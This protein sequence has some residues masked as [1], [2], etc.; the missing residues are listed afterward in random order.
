MIPFVVYLMGKKEQEV[1]F[2][3]DRT[4]KIPVALQVV[5]DDMGWH[6]G[7]DD[8]AGGG[9]SRSGLPRFHVAEDYRIINEIGRGIDMKIFCPFV[10]G[11]WDK[12]NYLR[13]IPDAN[14]DGEHWD[15]AS[16]I[17]MRNT[18]K[19]AEELKNSEFIEIGFHGLLHSYY[20]NGKLITETEFTR[21]YV[22]EEGKCDFSRSELVSAEEFTKHIDMFKKIYKSWGFTQK[23]R[24]FVSPCSVHTAPDESGDFVKVLKDNGFIYWSNYWQK[25]ADSTAVIDGVTF[26][27]KSWLGAGWEVYD[28]DPMYLI[29]QGSEEGLASNAPEG[30]INPAMGFHWTNFLRYNPENNMERLPQWIMYFKRQGKIFGQ[31]L[32]RDIAFAASQAVYSRFGKVSV[33]GNKYTV[34][35]SDVDN[36][37]ALGLSDEFY[38]S[39]RKPFDISSCTGGIMTI[40]ERHSYHTTYKIKRSG[41]DKV[42]VMLK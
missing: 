16:E 41:D 28:F 10:I 42:T 12:D 9:P 37:G 13:E 17:D 27:Q 7:R 25:A 34:D 5:V 14:P 6:N 36:K 32:A 23:I 8:R 2:M 39:S 18:E 21:P 35:L 1:L 22:D 31:M 29:D 3:K 20:E 4:V 24:G 15:R 30:V 26:L 19:C 38:I 33:D 40:Y 11:E